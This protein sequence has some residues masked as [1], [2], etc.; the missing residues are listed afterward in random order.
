MARSRYTITR[1]LGSIQRWLGRLE[2]RYVG[3][4]TTHG[5][6]VLAAMGGTLQNPG[7]HHLQCSLK[8]SIGALIRSDTPP[9]AG[10]CTG[11]RG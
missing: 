9:L 2:A 6:H 4:A 7:E 3:M 10:Q 5:Q 8:V 11:N 1:V